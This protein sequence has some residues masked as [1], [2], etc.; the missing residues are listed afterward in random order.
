MF[1]IFKKESNNNKL[2]AF[3][4]EAA[5]H[6]EH[7]RVIVTHKNKKYMARSIL[8]FTSS[9]NLKFTLT[10]C[11]ISNTP[12]LLILYAKTKKNTSIFLCHSANASHRYV[13]IY[14]W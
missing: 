5:Y 1:G 9:S 14:R 2:I 11:A 13:D 7:G 10:V 6:G 12:F 3:D 4:G 8:F